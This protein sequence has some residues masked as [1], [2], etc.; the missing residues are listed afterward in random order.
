MCF[1]H[2][3]H[4]AHLHHDPSEQTYLLIAFQQQ[5]ELIGDM[6][7]LLDFNELKAKTD[8]VRCG[9]DSIKYIKEMSNMSQR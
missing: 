7:D 3:V 1:T 5:A 8:E 2:S 9:T 4:C 6:H